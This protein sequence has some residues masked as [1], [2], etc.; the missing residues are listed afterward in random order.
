MANPDKN[1]FNVNQQ[2]LDAQQANQRSIDDSANQARCKN[3]NWGITPNA[4]ICENCG[5]WQLTGKCNFCYAEFE[6]GQRFCAECGNPPTGINCGQCGTLSHFDFCP[7]CNAALT[8]QSNETINMIANSVEFQNVVNV[9][10]APVDA[11]TFNTNAQSNQSDLEMTALK[12]YLSKFSEK[13]TKKKDMFSLNDSSGMNVQDNINSLEQS[14]QNITA[15]ERQELA[16]KQKE[17]LALQLLEETRNKTFPNNQEARKFFGALKILLP[18]V[19]QK[20]NPTGWRC[21]AY[22]NLHAGGPQECSA[23]CS[24]GTWI[25]ETKT[26]T[27]LNYTVI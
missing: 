17:S 12:N 25:Y 10:V 20:R 5:E 9:L 26:E 8:R 4:D 15:E 2:S 23:T 11:E 24:G 14:K 13:K 27:A 3:C 1:R 6:E 22:Y 18:Q 7:K 19:I 16:R 21:N